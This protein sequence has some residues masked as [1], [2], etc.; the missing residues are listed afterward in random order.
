LRG[1]RHNG[2]Y[3]VANMTIIILCLFITMSLIIMN[4]VAAQTYLG[5]PEYQIKEEPR[6][7]NPQWWPWESGCINCVYVGGFDDRDYKTCTTCK[8]TAIK[9]TFSFPDTNRAVIPS[10]NYLKGFVA[11]A[12]LTNKNSLDYGYRIGVEL[13][14]NEM[15]VWSEV[16]EFCEGLFPT[17]QCGFDKYIKLLHGVGV[18]IQ[19]SPSDKITVEMR[20]KD[21]NT[22]GFYYQINNGP[23]V[24][25][26]S[27]PRP[28]PAQSV[29]TLGYYTVE[30]NGR[31]AKYLQ[32][33]LFS[34]S[35]I[36]T[37]GW[38]LLIENPSFKVQNTW[39]LI[40]RARAVQGPNSWIDAIWYWGCYQYSNVDALYQ[41]NSNIGPYKVKFYYTSST[42]SDGTLLWG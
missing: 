15:I 11:A 30:V 22:V 1:P 2:L 26:S 36:G 18:V 42:L 28:D 3:A 8:A 16:W 38:N 19:A 14:R 5:P 24:E 25:F 10:N 17:S 37:G 31:T 33:S 27:F 6:G 32:F 20:W 23:I 21:S 4:A 39:Y 35:N 9:T 40:P 13:N 29:F 7:P 41:K 34:S 12:V